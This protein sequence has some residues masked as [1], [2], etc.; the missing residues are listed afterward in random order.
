[1]S[2]MTPTSVRRIGLTRE[3]SI[4]RLAFSGE[5]GLVTRVKSLPFARFD[6]ESRSWTCQVSTQSVDTLRRWYYEGL[7]G[8]AVDD[9]LEEGEEITPT[10]GAILRR[11]TSRRPYK[12]TM[13]IRNDALYSQLRAINGASW[14]K[15]TQSLTYP[16]A[17]AAALAEQ[18]TRGVI[19]DPDN[20]LSG[21]DVMVM[22]DTRTGRFV[23]QGD[24][25]AGAAFEKSFPKADMVAVWRERGIDVAFSDE[26]T[27]EVY[28][29]ELARARGGVDV[30]GFK[31]TL[32]PY[33]RESV[34]VALERSGFGI[35]H[36]MGLGKGHPV[37][38]PILSPAGWVNIEDLTVGDFVIG[39]DGRP[40]RLSGVHPRGELG[41]FRVGFTDGTSVLV[42]GDHLWS[43]SDG[44]EYQTMETR[45]LATRVTAGEVW[46]IPLVESVAFTGEEP[47]VDAYLLGVL[48]SDRGFTDNGCW[49]FS[50]DDPKLLFEVAG[51]LADTQYLREHGTGARAWT[52]GDDSTGG[53]FSRIMDD[54]G[55]GEYRP[56]PAAA[57]FA[58][59]LYRR[60]LLRGLM[61]ASG[62]LADGTSVFV[63]ARRALSDEVAELVRSLGGVAIQS[64]QNIDGREMHYVEV[65]TS[66][67]PFL[68]GSNARRWVTPAIE[69]AIISVEPAGRADVICLSVEAHDHLY[70]AQDYVVTHNTVVALAVGHELL[71]NRQEIRRVVLIVP[72]A[73]RTQWAE[74]IARFSDG[75]VVVIDGTAPKRREGYQ[76]A[77]TAPWVIVHYDVVSRDAR[78]LG[79]LMSG[80]LLVA[81]EAHRLKNPQA[82]RTKAVRLLA[83]RATR[84]L[85]LTGTPTMND[86]GEWYSIIS[87]FISPGCFGSPI[88]FLNRYSYPNRWG[89]FEGA[90]ELGE[91]SR[92]SS[93][94][95][96]RY[97]KSEVATHLPPLRIQHRGLDV[98]ATYRA[99]LV[100][101]HR[102]A[103]EEIKSAA[104][105]RAAGTGRI[106]LLDGEARDE[107][108]TGAEMTA[109]GMLRLLC[110]SP[111]I[112][113]A[114]DS[115]A[116]AAM[117]EAGLL[118]EGDGPKVEKLLDIALEVQANGERV[119][120]FSSSKRMVYLLS[121]RLNEAG[122]RHVT[123][124]GD[125]NRHDRDAAKAA[126][127]TPG[128][129]DDPG[130]TVFLSTDAGGEGL[131]LGAQCSLLVNMD[132][133][134]TPGVLAQRSARIHRLDGTAEHYLVINLT[135]KGT[136]EDGIMR[137]VENK[138][139]L[140]DAILG[141]G[142]G[143][144]RTTGRRTRSVFEEALDEWDERG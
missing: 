56:I 82:Q 130:P 95:Y 137:M 53:E 19:G 4:F 39:R 126:F 103:R 2:Q 114:S 60:F 98:D 11:G 21:A 132:I 25:R 101:A 108:E 86:P 140:A 89:G 88:D 40:T 5:P 20:L 35:F 64:T 97:T 26:G 125:T 83:S 10:P 61:D 115:P 84:R 50:A 30:E 33:Q 123:Y 63:S 129:P 59:S 127:T 128:T 94:Y 92:R 124:T 135:L 37:G 9:L 58:P 107:V 12:V 77:K 143:R 131:N 55:A 6:G 75:E 66:D 118:P 116:A 24:E 80:A 91:L 16:S 43:V 110:L 104:L 8:T 69:R 68:L 49:G 70:V 46:R 29:G 27:A 87:G 73:L 36:E 142:G 31:A 7:V 28:R 32:W 85:A 117:I 72:A 113:E 141:E 106:G 45:E 133:P 144:T 121:E 71:F 47:D 67:C 57:R 90:R 65:R 14:E 119:A 96:T 76:R 51:R 42:D 22:F 15:E 62:H 44:G 111:R 48:L 79:E 74:E 109:V 81:D 105:S 139:D 134:W 100:R 78:A 99:A 38:T 102:E 23:V 112:I 41:V 120:V 1:M 54:L 13:G 93:T 3:G 34:A 52:V 136:I 17:A 122:V 138:A 18:V